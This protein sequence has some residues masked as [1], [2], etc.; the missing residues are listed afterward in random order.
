MREAVGLACGLMR[1]GFVNTRS[2][3]GTEH[4]G[5]LVGGG[6]LAEGGRRAGDLGCSLGG[7]GRIGAF[8]R[9]GREVTVLLG[10]TDVGLPGPRC[11]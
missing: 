5:S 2:R 6:R 4:G 8:D 3:G 9:N 10:W 7:N 11:C 1:A